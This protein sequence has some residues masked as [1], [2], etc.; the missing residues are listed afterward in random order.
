MKR[1]SFF[2]GRPRAS[3][4]K[5]WHADMRTAV[6]DFELKVLDLIALGEPVPDSVLG[7]TPDEV[8]RHFEEAR[9]ELDSA[10]SLMLLAEAEAVLRVDYLLRVRRKEKDPVSRAFRELHK[11][12]EDSV[13][14]EQ[15]LLETWVTCHDGCKAAVSDF[16]GALN[17]RH[18]LAHGRYWTP[19]LG[20]RYAVRDVFE[21]ADR[22]FTH[23]PGVAGWA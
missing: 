15:E 23:L 16:K 21:I 14:L 18:W 10:A 20:R 12:K 11:V 8:A 5:Q 4:L 1:A 7:M 2:E 17:L 22:L 13:R 3:H 6:D 19:K 9:S